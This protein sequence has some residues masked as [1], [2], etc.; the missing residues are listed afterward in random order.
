MFINQ[1]KKVSFLFVSGSGLK[2]ERE[3]E[4]ESVQD[5]NDFKLNLTHSVPS[6]RLIQTASNLLVR[7]RHSNGDAIYI[8]IKQRP[9]VFYENNVYNL[10]LY[11]D[12]IDYH[13]TFEESLTL[14]LDGRCAIIDT[15]VL[16]RRGGEL[17]SNMIG[18]LFKAGVLE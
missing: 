15:K 6:R 7:C 17:M 14:K 11:T 13:M 18:K 3:Y 10:E 4:F 9:G 16:Q 2:E 5:A 12:I 8:P 1:S